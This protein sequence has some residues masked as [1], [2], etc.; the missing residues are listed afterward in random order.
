MSFGPVFQQ[1][2][3]HCYAIGGWAADDRAQKIKET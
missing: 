1:H 2:D 3:V